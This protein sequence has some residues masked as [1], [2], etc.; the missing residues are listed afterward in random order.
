MQLNSKQRNYL[1]KLAHSIDAVVRI[2]KSG[3]NENVLESIKQAIDK[4]ELIKVKILQNSSEKIDR[5]VTGKIEEYANCVTVCD[6]GNTI[7]L[8]K[9]KIDENKKRG[10]ITQMLYDFGKR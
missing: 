8:F 3:L 7:I 2:G 1:R 4:Q 9:E 5:L 6:I 10:Q